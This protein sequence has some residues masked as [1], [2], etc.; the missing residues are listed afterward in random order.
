M[1][2][3]E[4]LECALQTH[5]N[6]VIIA[7]EYG[8]RQKTLDDVVRDIADVVCARSELGKNFG[9]VLIPDGLVW[10]IPGMKSLLMAIEH[11]VNDKD[12][13]DDSTNF[14]EFKAELLECKLF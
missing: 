12:L 5:P 4:V 7:E 2:S 14:E 13:I 3:N 6:M 1:P 10:H 9:T 11:L 8:L